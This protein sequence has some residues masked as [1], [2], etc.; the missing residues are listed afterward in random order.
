MV[1]FL[2]AA[3][4]A[5]STPVPDASEPSHE[6]IM[7]HAVRLLDAPDGDDDDDDDRRFTPDPRVMDQE[8]ICPPPSRLR[9]WTA[10]MDPTQDGGVPGIYCKCG[11]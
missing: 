5:A 1:P 6:E 7:S 9:C 2:F 3:A 8:I 4:L 11:K 10:P